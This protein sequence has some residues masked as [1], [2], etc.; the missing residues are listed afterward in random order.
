MRKTSALLFVPALALGMTAFA[1]APAHAADQWSWQ[2]DL[3]QLNKS[4]ASGTA[5]VSVKGDQITVDIKASGLAK[6]FNGGAYPHV[7]H[8]HIDG[9]GVCPTPDADEDGDGVV[10]TPEGHMAYGEIG[11]TLTS[12]GDTSAKSALDVTRP[13]GQGSSVDYHRTFTVNDATLNALKNDTAVVVVHGL[14]PETLSAEAQKKDSSPLTKDLPLA[15]TA[16]A[17]CGALHASQMSMPN[18]AAGTGGGAVQGPDAG[19]LALGGSMI[20]AAG[21]AS[22]VIRRRAVLARSGR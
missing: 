1:A 8:I 9:M 21:A 16:P 18:G 17:L 14:D 15:A 10:S 5:M 13:L 20:L 4:G 7:S 22:V 3:G 12:K 11:T 2:A 6:T 19:L